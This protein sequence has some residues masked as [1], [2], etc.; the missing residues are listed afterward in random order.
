MK[1]YHIES[2]E[3]A[4]FYRAAIPVR[5]ILNFPQRG[6]FC[7]LFSPRPAAIPARGLHG[8]WVLFQ[9]RSALR[10]RRCFPHPV[11]PE[12]ALETGLE[13]DGEEMIV[14]QAGQAGRYRLRWVRSCQAATPQLPG[15][16]F[17]MDRS[18]SQPLG[19][20]TLRLQEVKWET[21]SGFFRALCAGSVKTKG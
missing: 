12:G 15:L 1:E 20:I 9:G 19:W 2:E 21:G 7:L 13:I 17:S 16:G 14:C 5:L 8:S 6:G 10:A 4:D 11:A 3:K 18:C